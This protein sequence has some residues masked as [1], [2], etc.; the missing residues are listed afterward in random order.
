VRRHP[1]VASGLKQ[2]CLTAEALAGVRVLDQPC[3]VADI[4]RRVDAVYTVSSLT[5]FE[6]LI[7]GLP[8]RCFGMPF[9]AGWGV[10]RDE[11]TSARRTRRRSVEELFAAAYILCS[12]YVDPLRGVATSLEDTIER[13]VLFRD[14]A[15]RHAGYTACL[16]YAP[17]KHGSARTLLYSPRGET[18]FH[19]RAPAAIRAAKARDGRVVFWAAR[20]TPALAAELTAAAVPVLRME[21][22]FVRSRGLGSD[23][24]RAASV[25]LDDLGVYYDATRPSR[26]E[27]ILETTAFD[28]TTLARAADLRRRLVAAGLSKYN[29]WTP[30]LTA[31]DWPAD[32]A[33]LLV[34][35]QVEND[36]S[37]LKGCESVRTN[38]GLLQ[39]ARADHPEAFLIFKPHPDVEAGNRPGAVDAR[40]L[41]D[42]ADAVVRDLDIDACIAGVDGLATMTSLAGFETL[43]RGKPVWTYGR[44]FFA[45]WGL[46]RDALDFPRRSRRLTLDQ[47]IAGALIAYPIYI[48]PPTGLPCTPEELVGFLEQDRQAAPDRGPKR[49][50]YWRAVFESLRRR[51]RARF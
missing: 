26:L 18:G 1:A 32:R 24:H 23:F 46:T 29:L 31:P 14:R 35:G 4:L 30:G 20:E 45:G 19:S 12:R 15:D 40:A 44:P 2:G 9:Y 7:H 13:L 27:G 6:A 25:V 22:G 10:T 38:L 43:L 17:W 28:Q 51:P 37:I 33:K 8:V 36:K 49:L 34:V 11:L 3:R 39:A 16:G 47:L 5:G 50:R 41:G 42:L 48:H 21:D